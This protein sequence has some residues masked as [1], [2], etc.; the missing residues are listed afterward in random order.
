M[1][2][3]YP[4]KGWQAY[5]DTFRTPFMILRALEYIFGRF[6]L[7]YRSLNN[8]TKDFI[9]R[10]KFYVLVFEVTFLF[11]LKNSFSNTYSNVFV[12]HNTM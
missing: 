4:I 3:W 5:P 2:A 1:Y 9:K 6:P 8:D 10:R 11:Y 12:V 7:C